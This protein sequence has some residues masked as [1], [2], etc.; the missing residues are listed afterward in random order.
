[1]GGDLA[2]KM[3]G[4]LYNIIREPNN[5]YFKENSKLVKLVQLCRGC[6]MII[7]CIFIPIVF[8]FK[9]PL[10]LL[11]LLLLVISDT[12]YFTD[13]LLEAFFVPFKVK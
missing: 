2:D 9:M 11:L 1:M 10:D 12:I 5:F 4:S 8:A 13:Q 6:S 3:N 7:F